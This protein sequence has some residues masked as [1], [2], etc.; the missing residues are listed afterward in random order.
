M[1]LRAK[2]AGYHIHHPFNV[3]MN[4]G[5]LTPDQVRGWIAN[6]FYYQV[7]IPRKDGAIIAN[8]PDRETRRLWVQRILDHDGNA[9]SPGG[10]EA[11]VRL[12]EAA[13]I[14]EQD[15]WS[16]RKSVV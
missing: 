11:W 2:G 13:G 6:R 14:P 9:D 15:L 5:E 10:I 7:N 4:N 1:Q 8:C 3:R 16:D 12:G